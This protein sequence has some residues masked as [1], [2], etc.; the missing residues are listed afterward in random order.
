MIPGSIIGSSEAAE[1]AAAVQAKNRLLVLYYPNGIHT[2]NWYP[3]A[4]ENE[5]LNPLA[6]LEYRDYELSPALR[7]L[8]RHRDDFLLIDGL[9][10]PLAKL[11]KNGDHAKAMSCY[12]TGVQIRMTATDDI[13]RP[14]ARSRRRADRSG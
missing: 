6:P 10:V 11:D 5:V 12:L 2:P 7:S 13:Q 3:E 9:N 14:G 1:K 4:P 8:A